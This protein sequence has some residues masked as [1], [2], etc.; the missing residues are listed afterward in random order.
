MDNA[1]LG[2]EDYQ[3]MNNDLGDYGYCDDEE[4]A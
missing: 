2:D 4:E 3:H 1:D